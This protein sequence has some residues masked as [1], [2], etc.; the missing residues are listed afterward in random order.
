MSDKETKMPT[1]TF[2]D[3][4]LEAALQYTASLKGAKRDQALFDYCVGACK[5]DAL[6]SGDATR[7]VPPWLF[8]LGVRGGVRVAEAERMTKEVG[9]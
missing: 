1:L 2:R 5:A 8:V 9:F 7:E 4:V 3:A 6:Q